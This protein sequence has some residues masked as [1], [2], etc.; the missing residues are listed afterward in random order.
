MSAIKSNSDDNLDKETLK[1][2][3]KQLKL[4][5]KQFKSIAKC[6]KCGSTSL[7]AN[8]KGFGVGKAVIGGSIAGPLGLVAG[9]IGAK[10]VNVT[11]LNCGKKFKL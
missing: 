2:Q 5:E 1:I 3:K 7:A 8:K 6:P 9:N 10:K 4:Q 11:C